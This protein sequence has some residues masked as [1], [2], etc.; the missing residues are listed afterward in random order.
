MVLTESHTLSKGV[1]APK[2]GV[3]IWCINDDHVVDSLA[4]LLHLEPVEDYREK[5]GA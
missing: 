5:D 1:T 3:G 4:M 2:V